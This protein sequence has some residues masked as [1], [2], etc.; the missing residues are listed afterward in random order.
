[1]KIPRKLLVE[2]LAD[3][4]LVGL[5]GAYVWQFSRIWLYG[6]VCFQEPNIAIR[7]LETCMFIAIL[8][9]GVKR[10]V[11]HCRRGVT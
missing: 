3:S 1:M 4:L 2:M 10:F 11:K 7:V 5:S 8:V 6:R 9:F